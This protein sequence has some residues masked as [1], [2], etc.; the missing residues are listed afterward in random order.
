MEPQNCT[1]NT[2]PDYYYNITQGRE[3][4]E[5]GSS[6]KS[7][8]VIYGGPLTGQGISQGDNDGC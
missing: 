8:Y 6:K 3:G 7:E 2:C 1:C 4:G 5:Q